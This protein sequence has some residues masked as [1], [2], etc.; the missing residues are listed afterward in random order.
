MKA[1]KYDT[2]TVVRGSLREASNAQIVLWLEGYPWADQSLITSESLSECEILLRRK[3]GSVPSRIKAWF[4]QFYEVE[5]GKD[6][7]ER[8]YLP[9]WILRHPVHGVLAVINPSLGVSYKQASFDYERAEEAT[10]V[11]KEIVAEG[12]SDGSLEWYLHDTKEVKIPSKEG[13]ID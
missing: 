1:T 3:G 8:K 2:F 11:L 13:T 10:T 9:Q 4:D 7:E 6:T 12:L 5:S